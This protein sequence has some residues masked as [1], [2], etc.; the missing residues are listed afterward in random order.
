VGTRTSWVGGGYA[1]RAEGPYS[2]VS[3]G[4]ENKAEAEWSSA[5]GG[6]QVKFNTQQGVYP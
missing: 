4:C 6:K 5:L 1:N 2:S 3:G